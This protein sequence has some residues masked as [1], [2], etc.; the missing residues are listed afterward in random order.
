MKLD[1]RLESKEVTNKGLRAHNIRQEQKRRAICKAKICILIGLAMLCQIWN[2]VPT[3]GRLRNVQVKADVIT[4]GKRANSRIKPVLKKEASNI[5]LMHRKRFLS[6]EIKTEHSITLKKSDNEYPTYTYKQD[7]SLDRVHLILPYEGDLLRYKRAYFNTLLEL[8]PSIYGYVSIWSGR[9]N[10]FFSFINSADVKEHKHKILASLL[11]LAEGIDVRLEIDESVSRTEL[12]LRKV[13]GEGEHFRVSMNVSVKTGKNAESLDVFEKVFQKRAVDV[14]NFFIENRESKVFTE[15]K[16]CSEP[17]HCKELEKV[18]F[19]NSP[20]FLIQTYIRHC[21]KST[22][23][24]ALFIQSVR[25]LLSEDMMQEKASPEKKQRKQT[26]AAQAKDLFSRYFIPDEQ[27]SND[28]QPMG[29]NR[30]TKFPFYNDCIDYWV[31]PLFLE[32]AAD[33]VP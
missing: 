7:H 5:G 28:S 25:D 16:Y 27:R 10:S 32:P 30:Q 6:P 19:V 20:R 2:A 15:G 11:L 21:L 13:G 22:E 23:K 9:K 31:N 3:L 14:A 24:I 8:F 18:Q 1:I 26:L 29:A 12:V 33:V 4:K 17:F